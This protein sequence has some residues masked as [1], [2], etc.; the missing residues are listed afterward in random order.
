MLKTCKSKILVSKSPAD[1]LPTYPYA[2]CRR[3]IV[4][5]TAG[6]IFGRVA[7]MLADMLATCRANTHMSVDLTIFSTFKNPTFPAK[8]TATTTTTKTANANATHKSE[9]GSGGVATKVVAARQGRQRW[10]NNGSANQKVQVRS[11]GYAC[12]HAPEGVVGDALP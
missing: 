3:N 9:E 10:R 4:S 5:N 6:T 7:D 12:Q 2:T 11:G 8:T 1:M